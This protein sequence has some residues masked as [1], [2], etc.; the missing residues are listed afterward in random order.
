MFST[1][2]T[3]SDSLASS[4]GKN[5]IPT[6]QPVVPSAFLTLFGSQMSENSFQGIAVITPA[7]SPEMLSAEVAPLCSMQE[8]ASRAWARMSCDASLVSEAIKP[9]NNTSM[10]LLQVAVIFKPSTT[11]S[12]VVTQTTLFPIS[13]TTPHAS[14]SSTRAAGTPCADE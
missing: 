3:D 6:A 2:F 11:L 12:I 4:R 10:S 5:T 9:Y 7:P 8:H 1:I 14:R 13:L